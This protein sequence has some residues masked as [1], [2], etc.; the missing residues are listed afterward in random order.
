MTVS[1]SRIIATLVGAA[2]GAVLG[3]VAASNGSLAAIGILV[4]AVAG[5]AFGFAD[6][7][8]RQPPKNPAH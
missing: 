6:C 3:L 2:V 8:W 7:C 5:A 1:S 4:L